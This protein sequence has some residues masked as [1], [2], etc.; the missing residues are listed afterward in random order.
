MSLFAARAKP[1]IAPMRGWAVALVFVLPRT[2]YAEDDP[3]R[4]L[5]QQVTLAYLS[6]GS[7]HAKADVV[8]EQVRDGRE[9]RFAFTT[10]VSW[11]DPQR[12]HA[13]YTRPGFGIPSAAEITSRPL[14]YDRLL[15]P[16]RFVLGLQHD[17]ERLIQ[18]TGARLLRE[19]VIVLIDKERPCDVLD[20]AYTIPQDGDELAEET[21]VRLWIDKTTHLALKEITVVERTI[22]PADRRISEKY[23]R[24]VLFRELDGGPSAGEAPPGT[25][26]RQGR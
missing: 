12:L 25:P 24:T 8:H 9:D 6:L 10:E 7:Y 11:S 17:H 22:G 23:T 14:M 2:A 26:P 5:I 16:H 21:R 19:E 15:R 20:L 13:S 3:A 18:L 1:T 4:R